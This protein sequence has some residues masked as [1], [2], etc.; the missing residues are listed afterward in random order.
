MCSTEFKRNI[1]QFLLSVNL[2]EEKSSSTEAIICKNGN[3]FF[4]EILIVHKLLTES[5]YMLCCPKSDYDIW[6]NQGITTVEKAVR[7]ETRTKRTCGL[8]R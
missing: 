5:K 1:K 4:L 8:G 3:V 2:T 7:K 6:D